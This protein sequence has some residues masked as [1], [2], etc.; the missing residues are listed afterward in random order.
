MSTDRAW[1]LWRKAGLQAAEAAEKRMPEQ[2]PPAAIADCSVVWAYDFVFD[3]C[4]NA[5]S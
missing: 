5:S 1:R 2:N 4:A 3:A